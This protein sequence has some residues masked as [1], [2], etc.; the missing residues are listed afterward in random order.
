MTKPFNYNDN[1]SVTTTKFL[2]SLVMDLSSM[3][4]KPNGDYYTSGRSK[5]VG[6]F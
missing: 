2:I 1:G 3:S 5:I 4:R 6:M